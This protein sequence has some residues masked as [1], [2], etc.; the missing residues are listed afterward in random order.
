G[1]P[2]GEGCRS[3]ASVRLAGPVGAFRIM[4]ARL[5]ATFAL[6]ARGRTRVSRAI[7]VNATDVRAALLAQ[8]GERLPAGVAGRAHRARIAG[9]RATSAEQRGR[10]EYR[11]EGDPPL[12]ASPR[13]RS[14]PSTRLADFSGRKLPSIER[15]SKDPRGALDVSAARPKRASGS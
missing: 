13:L 5:A 2:P 3:A 6:H 7:V 11:E 10:D 14:R 4:Q 9:R 8:P 12:H 15:E 1:G